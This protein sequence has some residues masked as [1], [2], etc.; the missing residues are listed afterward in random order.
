[1]GKILDDH[2]LLKRI[3]GIGYFLML[4]FAVLGIRLFPVFNFR[5]SHGYNLD[6]LKS[7][8]DF[9]NTKD[10]ISLLSRFDWCMNIIMFFFFPFALRALVP[11][12]RIYKIIV[13]AIFSSICIELMQ[14]ILDVGLADINDVIANSIG[15]VLGSM[16]ISV[17]DKFRKRQ[18]IKLT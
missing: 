11:G 16:V 7:V 12:A 15:G 13:L 14:Y 18:P 4:F 5:V 9:G 17:F 1:M 10:N 8:S 3:F 6:L 2:N